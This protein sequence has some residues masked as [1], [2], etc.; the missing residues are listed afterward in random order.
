MRSFGSDYPF[1]ETL[2]N[3]HLAKVVQ[4]EDCIKKISNW[5]KA[6][7]NI[8]YFCGNVGTGKTYFC[9]AWYN[10]LIEQKKRWVRA[11]VEYEFF[12]MLREEISKNF[13]PFHKI[14]SICECPYVILD[15]MGSSSMT[16]WQ[17]EML[18]E[19]INM[20][21]ESGFPTLITSNLTRKE[22]KEKFHD[23]FESRIFA[24]KNTVIELNGEDRRQESNFK[25]ER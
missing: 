15:D 18:F 1:G 25:E 5:V 9:A 8:F 24:S 22:L 17:K 7:S 13:D 12:T 10:H 3:A 4:S 20:R 14:K 21:N 23:R 2:R 16:E 6:E 19:F 11:F